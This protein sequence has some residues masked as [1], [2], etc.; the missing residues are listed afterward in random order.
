MHRGAFIPTLA[1][2]F[3]VDSGICVFQTKL[4][5]PWAGELS[6]ISAATGS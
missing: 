3:D 2:K 6:G 5:A 1:Q 4:D